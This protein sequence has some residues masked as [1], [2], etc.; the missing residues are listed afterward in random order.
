MVWKRV[1]NID[2]IIA[3]IKVRTKLGHLVMQI[4]TELGK[5]DGSDDVSYET[6]CR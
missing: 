6:I 4:F 2:E 5:V 3:D 1:E